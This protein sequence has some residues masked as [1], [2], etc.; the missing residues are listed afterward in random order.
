[1]G[2]GWGIALSSLA[3][4]LLHVATNVHDIVA[5]AAAG[6][7]MQGTGSIGFAVATQRTGNLLATSVT[8]VVFNSIG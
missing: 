5:G 3:F 7:V 4:G 2:A 6:I 8:H 1:M